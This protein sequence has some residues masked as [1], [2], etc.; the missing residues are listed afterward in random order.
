VVQARVINN[1]TT[2]AKPGN[3]TRVPQNNTLDTSV[4]IYEG[5]ISKANSTFSPSV[6]L[7]IPSDAP[8]PTTGDRFT[9]IADRVTMQIYN[10]N[11]TF[12]AFQEQGFG[13]LE[14]NVFDVNVNNNSLAYG[15]NWI[16]S[17]TTAIAQLAN[18]TDSAY[19]NATV[20]ALN[21]TAQGTLLNFTMIGSGTAT[22]GTLVNGTTINGT[23]IIQQSVQ[24][25]INE[26][27]ANLYSATEVLPNS[28]M[29]S[30]DFF[31]GTLRSAG[32]LRNQSESVN[33][34][35]TAGNLTM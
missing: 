33:N 35:A 24:A 31:A 2:L 21:S 34:L 14:Y 8:A 23:T 30:L 15:A 20:Q 7:T 32:V 19:I 25:Y 11:E 26:I 5:P 29:T 9:V 12:Q 18:M 3:W 13:L 22:N 4:L 10:S 27:T 28:T 1:A 16:L 6:Q 17:N